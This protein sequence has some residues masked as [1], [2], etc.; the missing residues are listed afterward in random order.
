[1]MI[2]K[3]AKICPHCRKTLVSVWP[4]IV[5][6]GVGLFFFFIFI[7]GK[8]Q[9][10]SKHP[11]QNEPQAIQNDF[12]PPQGAISAKDLYDAYKANEVAADEKFK[13]KRLVVYGKIKDI[14][15]NIADQPSVTLDAGTLSFVDCRFPKDKTSQL[16]PLQKGQMTAI[17]CTA[18]YEMVATVF[19]Y[20][21]EFR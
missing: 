1:M 17:E 6:V 4:A 12:N 20:D 16:A 13:G 8:N 9:T 18:N 10:V 11:P 21:C 2:P 5:I 15:K 3:D 19:L 14:S 7:S